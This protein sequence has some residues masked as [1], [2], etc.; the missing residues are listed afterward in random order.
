MKSKEKKRIEIPEA[1][2]KILD[3]RFRKYQL[4]PEKLLTLNE[5]MERIDKRI[6][7]NSNK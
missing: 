1:H 7:N 5:L 6:S 2:K 3:E 4:F